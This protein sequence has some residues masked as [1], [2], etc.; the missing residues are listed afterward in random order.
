MSRWQAAAD[1]A[2]AVINLNQY[3]LYGTSTTYGKIF[4]DFFNKEVIFARVY[5]NVFED[6]YNTVYRD[7][8]PNG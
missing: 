5:G 6:R 7:L 8:S 2:L 4:T 3:A 1:A